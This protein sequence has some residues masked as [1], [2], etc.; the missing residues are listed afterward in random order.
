MMFLCREE[1]DGILSSGPGIEREVIYAAYRQFEGIPEQWFIPRADN[2]VTLATS[3]SMG[4][5]RYVSASRL[6]DFSVLGAIVALLLIHGIAPGKL[7]PVVL[8]YFVYGCNIASVHPAFLR[9]WHPDIHDTVTRWIAAGPSG[10]IDFCRAHFAS[11][12]DISVGP[13]L[14]VG[15]SHLLTSLF[16]INRLLSFVIGMTSLTR[17]LQARCFIKVSSVLSS[18]IIL[19]YRLLSKDSIWL[20]GM[21][22]IFPR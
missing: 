18:P 5:A 3:H 21:A 9:E 14:V 7:D 16:F 17:L 15:L 11:Y 13:N 2:L 12:H 6:S 8:Q 10:C 20:V 19:K 4:T 1:E 22:L